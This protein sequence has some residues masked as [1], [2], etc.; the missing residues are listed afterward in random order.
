MCAVR[1]RIDHIACRG[2]MG[3]DAVPAMIA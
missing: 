2:E 1:L 3:F